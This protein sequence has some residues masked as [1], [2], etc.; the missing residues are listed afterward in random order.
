MAITHQPDRRTAEAPTGQR[1]V[2]VG[3]RQQVVV[4]TTV[5]QM[6]L[7]PEGVSEEIVG[8]ADAPL[9]R[10]WI[11]QASAPSAS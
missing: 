7:G 8:F 10:G 11:S 6:G 3:E 5:V 9:E 1:R 2:D 4:R